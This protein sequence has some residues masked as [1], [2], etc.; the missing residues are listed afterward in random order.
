MARKE[1]FTCDACGKGMPIEGSVLIIQWS[2]KEKY[3]DLCEECEGEILDFINS[4][5]EK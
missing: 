4:L 3:W 1:V 2:S 5:E